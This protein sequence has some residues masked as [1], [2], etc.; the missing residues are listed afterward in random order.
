MSNDLKV[1]ELEKLVE[2]HVGKPSIVGLLR[3][4]RYQHKLEVALA[5]GPEEFTKVVNEVIF[6]N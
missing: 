2:K 5:K 4:K 1:R 3:I 6:K